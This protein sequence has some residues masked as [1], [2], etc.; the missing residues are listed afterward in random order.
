MAEPNEVSPEQA[1][2]LLA[3]G[4]SYLDVRSEKEFEAGHPPGAYNVPINQP[5]PG[6]VVPNPDFVAVVERVLG[7]QAKIVVGCKTGVR[8]RRAA[9]QLKQAGFTGVVEMPAGWDA[10]RDPF[11]QLLPGWSRL[12]LPSELGA[13]PGRAYPDLKRAG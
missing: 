6:G 3:D 10:A 2:A 13:P 1:Q 7:K 5:A 8:S 4:Y 9:E 11:G 12:G